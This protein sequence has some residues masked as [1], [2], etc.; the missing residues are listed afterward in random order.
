MEI[1]KASDLGFCF[2]VRRA[3]KLVEEAARKQGPLQTLGP[4]VH[5]RQVIEEL[6]AKGIEVAPGLHAIDSETVAIASH[7]IAPQVVDMLESR[8][9]KVI[10]ATCPLVQRAQRAARRLAAAGFFVL[11]FGDS[12]HSEVRGIL[13][14]A[15]DN[16]LAAL[17]APKLERLPRR[18][19]VL[20]QTTQSAA[21]FA[22]FLQQLINSGIAS[23]SELRI[24]NTICEATTKRQQAAL[25]LAGR[26]DLMIVI[27]GRDSA[28]TRHLA[29]SCAAAGVETHHVETAAEL[30]PAWLVNRHRIGVTAGASTPDWIIDEVITKL[31]EMAK[32]D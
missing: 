11:V 18:V 7:G 10:D 12:A 21:N 1:E 19:G 26:V 4:I 22:R 23:L 14:W 25:E 17:E 8:G 28:N 9:L 29:E 6:K 27:G 24:I 31:E 20:S 2:G 32:N 5:N 16:A 13:G 30:D 3:I 15:G